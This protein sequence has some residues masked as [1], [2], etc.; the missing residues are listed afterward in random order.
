L[1]LKAAKFSISRFP[2]LSKPWRRFC[3]TLYIFATFSDRRAEIGHGVFFTEQLTLYSAFFG[4]PNYDH[5]TERPR[6][7]A[8]APQKLRVERLPPPLGMPDLEPGFRAA[9]GDYSADG[10]LGCTGQAS[11]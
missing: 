11:A 5:F 3:F 9:F 10:G 8:E 1:V 4:K 6:T 2:T 7:S